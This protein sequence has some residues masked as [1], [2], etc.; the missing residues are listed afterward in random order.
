M[1]KKD[2]EIQN[3]EAIEDIIN[4]AMVCRLALSENN[5][6]YIIPVC[7][8]YK[9]QTLYFHTGQKG[10]KLNILRKNDNVCVEFDI[11]HKIVEGDEAC[12]WSM[13]YRS[14]IGFGKA[15]FIDDNKSKRD[16]LDIIM[17]HYSDDSFEYKEK[18]VKATTIIQVKIDSMTGKKSGH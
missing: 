6:P 3:I 9:N 17:R 16:A 7:F 8:G 4:R 12:K 10:K 2:K 15:S 13:K 14:V 5:R 1:G 18:V 11:D